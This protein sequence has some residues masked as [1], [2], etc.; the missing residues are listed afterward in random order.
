MQFNNTADRNGMIQ[1]FEFWTS[2]GDGVVSGD[3]VLLK[4]ATSLI[5]SSFDEI[6]PFIL[7]ADVNWRF[8]DTNYTDFPIATT[9]LSSGISDY[10]FMQDEDGNSIFDIEK[11]YFKS[12]SSTDQYTSLLPVDPRS[13]NRPE[14]YADNPTANVGVPRE[15]SKRGSSI[16]L[17][18]KP[19][20]NATRGLK[21]VFRR[22]PSY[23]TSTDT[24]KQPG[25][26]SLFHRILPMIASHSWIIV[27]KPESSMLI[28]RIEERI[29]ESK[30]EL[31]TFLSKRS[32]DR[33]P[34][35]MGSSINA[36]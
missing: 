28:T 22:S 11:V 9:N 6:M 31:A 35:F 23:F 26:P 33:T 21:V 2:L 14:I 29:K 8:D 32:R 18:P 3:A 20:Y 34:R 1:D 13:D 5:N 24:T 30:N 4:R 7:K 10:N 36:N 19:D 16:F 15:Y 17:Y 27:N 25:V 12:S